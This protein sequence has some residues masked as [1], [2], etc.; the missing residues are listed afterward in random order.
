MKAAGPA[1]VCVLLAAGAFGLRSL[2]D[3]REAARNARRLDAIEVRPLVA[4]GETEW[5]DGEGV[6]NPVAAIGVQTGRGKGFTFARSGGLWRCLE[7]YGAVASESRLIGLMESLGNASRLVA[8]E[9]GDVA[10]YGL[11]A[12]ERTVLTLH[13]PGLLSD[14]DRDV[15]VSIELG[16]SIQGA[17]GCYARVSGSN[18]ILEVDTDLAR[19]LEDPPPLEGAPRPLPREEVPPLLDLR[20]VP[21]AWPGTRLPLRRVTVERDDGTGF[22]MEL[23]D[24]GEFGPNG[25][26][27]V[28]RYRIREEGEF[29]TGTDSHP[30]LGTGYTL[31]LFRASAIEVVDPRTIDPA[32]ARSP[33]ATVTLEVDEGPPLVLRI[34]SGGFGA[35]PIVV[36][37]YSQSAVRVWS[38]ITDLLAPEAVQLIE[39]SLGNPWDG[40]LR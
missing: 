5:L 3:A 28:P 22:A 16:A 32:A 15:L 21:T 30:V 26:P 10:A 1:A 4:P 23:V 18:R 14:E 8:A 20:L 36:D 9:E 27:P 35:E 2:A 13:G 29:G 11:G 12:A 38:R 37:D 24:A 31:F 17:S 19:L 25:E 40:F 7:Y 34:L 39:P 6:P 33:L